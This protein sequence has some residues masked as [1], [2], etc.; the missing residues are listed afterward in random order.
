ME[1]QPMTFE[2][3]KGNMAMPYSEES[4]KS[5]ERL[6]KIE[7]QKEFDSMLQREYNEYLDNFN[8]NWLLK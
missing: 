8:G 3:W 5:L 7:A 6:H 2:E 1:N 4:V